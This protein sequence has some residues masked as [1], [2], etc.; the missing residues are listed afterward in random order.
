MSGT[1]AN[2]IPI[3]RDTVSNCACAVQLHTTPTAV[4]ESSL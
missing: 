4:G 1:V 2:R 3:Y